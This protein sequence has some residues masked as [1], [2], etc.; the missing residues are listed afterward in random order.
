MHRRDLLSTALGAGA[1]ALLGDRL[2]AE[3]PQQPIDAAQDK[4]PLLAMLAYPGMFP[5]D[6]VAPEAVFSGMRTH[7][8]AI[9]WKDLG[10][11]RADSGLG[12]APTMTFADAPADVDILFV[13]GGALGTLRVMEDPAV[14][15]FLASRAPKARYVTSVCTGSLVLAAAGLL[16]GYRAT[17]HWALR[18]RLAALGAIP[19]NERVVEDRNRVTGAGVTAGADM[20]L[21]LASRLVGEP[22]AKAI[23]LNIEYDP[24]PPFD[25]G[26]PERAGA[27]VA[28][29]LNAAYQ[30]LYT[31]ADGVVAR[32]RRQLGIA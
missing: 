1:V 32:V 31:L 11:L 18:D 17:S 14:L 7:R 22:Y 27:E 26:T 19:V 20:A 6:L 28:A 15:D 4:R 5:L 2:R 8:I 13:P 24:K 25:A 21:T 10:I 29:M 3:E 23:A 12:I 9:V 30:P 16:R